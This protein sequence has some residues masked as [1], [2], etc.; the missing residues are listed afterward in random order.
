MAPPRLCVAIV[1][2][3]LLALA[4]CSAP[5]SP[6][7]VQSADRVPSAGLTGTSSSTPSTAPAPI[8]TAVDGDGQSQQTT[9]VGTRTPPRGRDVGESAA[10]P[11]RGSLPV[12]ATTVYR[13]VERLMNVSDEPPTVVFEDDEGRTGPSLNVR[14]S[15]RALGFTSETGSWRTCGAF[16]SALSYDDRIRISTTNL[17]ASAVELVL[18]HEYVHTLQQEVPGFTNASRRADL[19]H[20]ALSEGSAVYVADAYARQY[21]L[22]WSGERP[23]EI[24]RCLYERSANR[25]RMLAGEYYFGARYFDER[26]SS[27]R[28]L[29]T[30][31]ASP[32]QTQ[33]QLVHV[34]TPESEPAAPLSVTVRDSA[35]WSERRRE[36][37]GEITLRT[38]LSIGL[39]DS[40]V[41]TV[42]TGWANATLVPFDADDGTSVA[43]ILRWD[44]PTDAEEFV[45]GVDDLRQ[46]IQ[47]RTTVRTSRLS[48][49]TVVVFAGERSF[50]TGATASV[51]GTNVTVSAP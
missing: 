47:D 44:S 50:V 43:W 1:L 34:E 13:R 11:V 26:L 46:A 31:F 20:G 30:V 15:H 4:G 24:R 12:D 33:E 36:S 49:D 9:S 48:T 45:A 7:A 16:A 8:T 40:R 6:T 14:P 27:P 37:G 39:P 3:T 28:N 10:V 18:V 23:L 19:T 41:D 38:W 21:D 35:N 42:A 2:A 29:S 25:L 5:S 32:P 22:R 17:S 51:A